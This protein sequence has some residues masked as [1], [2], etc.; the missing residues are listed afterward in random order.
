MSIK[1]TPPPGGGGHDRGGGGVRGNMNYA[2]RLKT[3]VRYDQ[4]LKRNLLEITLE[5]TKTEAEFNDVDPEDIERVFKTLGIDIVNQVEGYQ[6]HYKGN[7]SIISV[8]MKAGVTLDRFC[9]DIHI[10]VTESIMTGNIRPAGK[11]DV[12]VSIVGLDFNTPDNLTVDYM[13]KFGVVLS[14][15]VIYSKYDSGPFQGK[16]N[17]E[18]KYQVDFSKSS[19]Q[20]GTYHIIDGCKA[21]V[22]YR[23]NKKTCG[24]CH[25][26]ASECTGGAIARNCAIGGGER[27]FLSDHMKKLWEEIGFVPTTFELDEN[28]K[29]EDDV[30]Q[31]VK[32]APKINETSFPSSM[33]HPEPS[34]RDIEHF[35]G[36][37]IRNIPNTLEDKDIVDFLMN[38]GL[39]HDHDIMNLRINKGD[40]NTHVVIDCLSPNDVQTMYMNIHFLESKQ[41]FFDVPLYCKCL[42]NMTPVKKTPPEADNAET[43]KE[44]ISTEVTEPENIKDDKPKIPGLPEVDRQKKKRKKKKKSKDEKDDVK[45]SNLSMSDFLISPGSGLVK[46]GLDKTKDFVFSD[47]DSEGDSDNSEEA[48]E[49]S[50]ESFSDNDETA[51]AVDIFTPANPKITF[52]RTLYAKLASTTSKREANSPAEDKLTKKSRA[53]SQSRTST[54]NPKKK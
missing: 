38:H 7:I 23:G 16:Y 52:V 20:M 3:N 53:R 2:D 40:K 1:T 41:K 12:T 22:F 14:N 24:R 37:T 33:K 48:F 54:R 28:E 10:K 15:T 18:R 34:A 44:T 51:A 13:N 36:V 42:R 19:R 43:T 26:I 47:Y 8:W 6:I 49:D 39:P 9:K 46:E 35:D 27:V 17:G 31:A 21:R 4:R 30:E 32:D 25:K 11:K 5:K 50:K 45:S 29:T